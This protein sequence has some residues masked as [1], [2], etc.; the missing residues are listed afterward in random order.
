[1]GMMLYRSIISPVVLLC[2]QAALLSPLL[3]NGQDLECQPSLEL[4]HLS[5]LCADE[6]GTTP[7]YPV[8]QLCAPLANISF[9]DEHYSL[10]CTMEG[11]Q[12]YFAPRNWQVEQEILREGD[13]GVDVT[14]AP[15]AQLVEGAD[16]ALAFAAPGG[17]LRLRRVIPAE[18]YM[19]F[20]LVKVGSSIYFSPTTTVYINGE[21]A[22]RVAPGS[23][24]LSY[25]SSLLM[26]G[27]TLEIHIENDA[28]SVET[29]YLRNFSFFSNASGVTIREWTALDTEGRSV[30]ARQFIV[31]TT[32]SL[33]DV[34]FPGDLPTVI[35]DPE[36]PHTLG[37]PYLDRDGDPKTLDDQFSLQQ[38]QCS[39]E[40]D[41][42]DE[43]ILQDDE[44]LLLRHW[45]IT[46]VCG[47]NTLEEKQLFRVLPSSSSQ[48]I[49]PLVPLKN[50]NVPRP[51]TSPTSVG[52]SSMLE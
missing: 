33:A 14:G 2:F 22:Q 42:W 12:G 34:R 51:T 7:L 40:L 19:A 23:D 24:E 8:M 10:D 43:P 26:V 5:L 28:T 16:G 49:S 52:S 45:T 47:Q 32:P 25:F 36:I 6:S 27:D 9:E 41:Y 13:G 35:P 29:I 20:D 39:F 11:L 48:G 31:F 15:D 46:D 50:L 30:S 21:M 3:V 18:G 38:G 44:N 4:Q 1:M 17:I 37:I